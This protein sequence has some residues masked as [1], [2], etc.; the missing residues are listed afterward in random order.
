MQRRDF[1]AALLGTL[2]GSACTAQRDA[3]PNNLIDV[4]LAVGGMAQLVYLPTTLAQRLG[5]Y[6]EEGLNVQLQDFPGGAKALQAMLGGSAD[7]V[8][9]F[10]DHTL[11][12]A[13]EGRALQSFVSILQYPGL[14]LVASPATKRPVDRIA[15]FRGATVGV[16]APGSSTHFF[17]NYL[18]RK[19][20]VDPDEVAVVGIGH[21]ATALAAVQ[22]GRVDA[23][24][25]TDPALAQLVRSAPRLAILADTRTPEGV[26]DLFGVKQY[27]ASVFYSQRSWMGRH[28]DTA[29]RLARAMKRTLH[30]ISTHT[31][32]QIAARMPPEHVGP[33][34]SLYEE[35]LMMSMGIYSPD[36]V[37]QPEGP[38]AVLEVL[39]LSIKALKNATIDLAA[40]YTNEFVAET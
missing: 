8:S 17:L 20:L 34:R 24:V 12:M 23:A 33:D 1:S 18:L 32:Q 25:V 9:G 3:A 11:Q 28:K 21:G 19:H 35:A 31:A 4:R 37:M 29:R 14:A 10:Y 22:T 16:T 5:H 26:R 7:V 38:K 6:R 13:V 15:H 30:W 40:T 36:G 2:A 39:S 27:P